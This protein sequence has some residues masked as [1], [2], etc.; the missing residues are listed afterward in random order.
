MGSCAYTGGVLT[1]KPACRRVTLHPTTQ[2][3]P[4]RP[5]PPFSEW[6]LFRKLLPEDI[7]NDLDPKAPQSAYTPSVVSWL[8][9]YQRLHGNA[10]LN[11]AV[12]EF[13]QRFPPHALP[14]CKRARDGHLSANSGAYSLARTKLDL[15]VL[16][17]A[18]DHVFDS[19]VDAYP[20]SWR[21]RRIFILDGTT[22]QLPA[23]PELRFA[24]PP[25]SNQ[26]G[27]SHW[28]ILQLLVAHELAS[29]LAAF[30]EFGPMYG[31]QATSELTLAR[32]IAARLPEGSI[33]LA[34]RNF[35]VF[36]FAWAAVEAKHDT[37]V[38][39]TAGRFH[40][41]RKKARWLEEGKWELTW[42]PS[43]WDRSAHPELPA[44]AEVKGWLYEVQISPKL[45]LWLFTTVEGTATEIAAV[46][47]QR[48]N[49][50]TDIRDLKETLKLS[51][52]TGKSIAMVEKELAAAMIAYNLVNQV[53]HLAAARLEIAPRRLSF[54]G[55]W[56]LLK[57]FMSGLLASKTEEQMQQAFERLLRGA[58]QRKLPRRPGRS[59]PREVIPRQAKSQQR[60]HARKPT[61]T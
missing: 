39:L 21:D 5:P 35:G 42:R 36:A 4:D 20:P 28:P 10:T 23:T 15:R 29:G 25:A 8:L 27:Q 24:F 40:S 34:D 30:P 32:R 43:R 9:I 52:M 48:Q 45:T 49:V 1:R 31:P 33:L 58:G 11:D 18:A 56:S 41:M 19:L 22:V 16:Y 60:K 2:P 3:P 55:V 13:T 26:H 14:D 17:W 50:E 51:Q 38:R 47:H 59:Y 37:L 44:G 53:R 54:A 57:A 12:S 7:L 6:L 46:Y 61:P